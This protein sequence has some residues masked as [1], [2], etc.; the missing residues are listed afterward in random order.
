[1]DDSVVI[2]KA[3]GR[4]TNIRQEPGEPQYE[5]ADGD[6]GVLTWEWHKEDMKYLQP[7][8]IWDDPLRRPRTVHFGRVVPIGIQRGSCRVYI[9]NL[10]PEAL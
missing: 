6:V 9:D 10:L 7:L 1:V 4:G 3:V 8:V 5:F 2:V